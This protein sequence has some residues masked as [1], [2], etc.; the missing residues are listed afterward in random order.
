MQSNQIDPLTNQNT[1]SAATDEALLAKLNP[2]QRRAVLTSE[3]PLLVLAGAGSGKTRVITRRVAWLVQH[4]GV[5][6]AQIL[7]ITFTNKAANEMKERIASLIG[8]RARG[9]WIGPFHSMM[10]RILRRHAEFLG[11]R[12]QFAIFDTS[13]QERVM[14]DVLEELNISKRTL[15]PREALNRVGGFKNKGM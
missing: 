15:T 8:I 4:K 1:A 5:H 9:A 12:P 10:L 14:R 7:A 11:F 3:G 2:E 13:D 6:P